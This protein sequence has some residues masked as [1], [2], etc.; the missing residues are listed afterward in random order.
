MEAVGLED[1]VSGRREAGQADRL[2]DDLRDIHFLLVQLKFVRLY[3]GEIQDVIDEVQQVQAAFADV[4]PV[5]L[6][7]LVAVRTEDLV[8]QLDAIEQRRS[9][10]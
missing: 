5:F 9:K 3:F 2:L 1:H 4:R 10:A 8:D 7:F 6:I